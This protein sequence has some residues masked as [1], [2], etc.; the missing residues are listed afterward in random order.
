M[1]H[2]G[3]AV[4]VIVGTG[5]VRMW[6]GDPGGRL[7]HQYSDSGRKQL[8][9][10]FLYSSSPRIPVQFV[11]KRCSTRFHQFSIA[12]IIPVNLCNNLS[13]FSSS[14]AQGEHKTVFSVL[15]YPW[16]A[17]SIGCDNGQTKCICFTENDG[18]T[19][20]PGW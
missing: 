10:Q 9:E 4:V 15:D 8:V 18:R 16:Y 14:S 1:V 11:I 2:C 6:G 19:I 13:V 3:G 7:H 20:T 12:L 17:A 5:V